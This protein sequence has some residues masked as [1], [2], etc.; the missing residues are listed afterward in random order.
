MKAHWETD[1]LPDSDLTVLIRLPDG[2]FPVWPAFHDG[3][4]WRSADGVTL[5]GPVQ[6]WMHLE[7]A[8]AILDG[9]LEGLRP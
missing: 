5:Q 2:E 6:G 4:K 3:E 8:A 7:T 1:S 9:K